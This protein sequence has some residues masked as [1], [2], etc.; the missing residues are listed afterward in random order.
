MQVD[1]EASAE[2][3][4]K[5][6]AASRGS[7]ECKGVEVDLDGTGR[8]TFIDHDVDAVIFHGRVEIL[9]YHGRETVYL[10]DKEHVVALE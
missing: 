9:L 10:V 7:D 2:R 6:S 8:R 3:S 4:G 5:E 1:A